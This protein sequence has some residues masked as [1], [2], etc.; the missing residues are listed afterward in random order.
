MRWVSALGALCII[1]FLG[2]SA[3]HAQYL[4][5]PT[6]PT[7]PCDNSNIVANTHWVTVCGGGGGGGGV[8][9]PSAGDLI[10]STGTNAP[11]GISE[12]DGDCAIGISGVW[13]TGPCG[14]GTV[15]SVGLTTPSWL[16]VTGSPITGAGVL[17]VTGT[18]EGANM[19]LASPDGSSGPLSPRALVAGDISL[20]NTDFL[21]G[22]ASGIATPV[23]MG[24]SC[25]LANT[26]AIT[27]EI[28][29]T[30]IQTF[31]LSGSTTTLA[32]TSGSLTNTHC[33]E[34][35]ASGNFVDAGGTCTTGGGGGTVSSGTGPAIAQYNTG[36]GTV[37]GPATVSGD[38]TIAQGGAVTVGSIGGQT[39]SLGGSLTTAA[40]LHQT[41]GGAMTLAGPSLP[42]TYTLPGTTDT[43]SGLGTVQTF[44][45]AQ[46]F[47]NGDF[48]LL[49][50]SSGHSTLEAPATGGG[51][52][53]LPG[54]AVTL[55]GN[56]L[57]SADVFVGNGSSVATGVPITGDVALLNTGATTVGKIQGNT[58]PT[59]ATTDG[60]LLIGNSATGNWAK[61][62]ITAGTNVTVTNGNGTITIAAS[63]GGGSSCPSG[64][65]TWDGTTNLTVGATTGLVYTIG[66]T[67]VAAAR[68]LTLPV[69]ATFGVACTLSVIDAA[70]IFNSTH[71]VT[72]TRQSSDTIDG[73]TTGTPLEPASPIVQTTQF[74]VVASGL[75]NTLKAPSV[76][77]FT[78][79]THEF[80]TG[81]SATGFSAA[82]PAFTDISAAATF[83][84]LP[85]VTGPVIVGRVTNTSGALSAAYTPSNGTDT[86]VAL[87][88]SSF[89]VGDAVKANDTSGT[90]VDAGVAAGLT[91][92]DIGYIAGVNL[93][94]NP[95]EVSI[96][97]PVGM[98]ITSMIGHV[99]AA[100]GGTATIDIYEA[101]SGT[102]CAS[103][104]KL[105]NT[106]SF[107]AN[108]TA[109]T[110]QTLAG[111]TATITANDRLCLVAAGAG[112]A[113]SVG[114]GGI[115]VWAHP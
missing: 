90:I 99:G 35:D 108:G 13:R 114:T 17:A 71:A 79:V 39:V 94:T 66:S 22:N 23:A 111:T 29:G 84:Q 55:L 96:K 9:W 37:V 30:P 93:S 1:L 32:T 60:Q 25:S 63:G 27:C 69:A 107:N 102:A 92:F 88:H 53:T 78:P 6:A 82:Q 16:T 41:G 110:D 47:T 87:A 52:I 75:W 54:G 5:A 64:V 31:T 113:S 12:I 48:Q 77:S 97:I 74:T 89:T 67:P 28:A 100:V 40:A 14:V 105:T 83:A 4:V 73:S 3:A 85:A 72:P 20:P 56:G 38:A 26:G 21:V 61:S 34:I 109:N 86:E 58:V 68:T 70:Q 8:I 76:G 115:T 80:L 81:V 15:T 19:V 45:A 10:I 103:G 51:I 101:P 42:A 44:T 18:S 7:S 106:T 112:W 62:T 104:T 11:A 65:T 43:L 50:S 33:V 59:G 24:G 91:H 98:T 95:T 46:S 57:A 49:G 2:A 36:T